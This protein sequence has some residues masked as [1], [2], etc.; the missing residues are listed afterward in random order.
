M[1]NR[2][3]VSTEVVKCRECEFDDRNVGN[4]RG[5]GGYYEII[6]KWPLAKLASKS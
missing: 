4:E 6:T 5:K 2:K 1:A 3:R